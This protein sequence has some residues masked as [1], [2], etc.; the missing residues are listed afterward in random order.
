MFGEE[1]VVAVA[2]AL[3][4]ASHLGVAPVADVPECHQ[5]VAPEVAGVARRD[6]P[7]TVAIEELFV[8]RRQ[9]LQL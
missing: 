1:L 4:D 3:E 6:V 2:I 5:R 9:Q 8:G 7:A